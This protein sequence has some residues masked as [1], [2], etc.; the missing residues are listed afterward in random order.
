MNGLIVKFPE[1]WK[2]GLET[3]EERRLPFARCGSQK[4]DRVSTL[5]F[6]KASIRRYFPCQLYSLQ[7]RYF[8]WALPL[9]IPTIIVGY[10]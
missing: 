9:Q 6:G 4:D 5:G 3:N 7:S 2:S 1:T 8:K 10:F